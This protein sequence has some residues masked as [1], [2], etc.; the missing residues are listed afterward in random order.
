[1]RYQ[2]LKTK[3]YSYTIQDL[4]QCQLLKTTLPATTLPLRVFVSETSTPTTTTPNPLLSTSLKDMNNFN[5]N[6]KSTFLKLE[7]TPALT[8][9]FQVQKL[10]NDYSNS[11]KNSIDSDDFISELSSSKIKKTL[12]VVLFVL[13]I[14]IVLMSGILLGY[15][16]RAT[17]SIKQF[18]KKFNIITRLVK[19]KFS[20]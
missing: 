8:T 17:N 3:S 10:D 20:S 9:V 5:N 18:K 15:V 16:L 1:M 4:E 7:N 6:Q 12:V 11:T 14:S 19:S 13:I 2:N